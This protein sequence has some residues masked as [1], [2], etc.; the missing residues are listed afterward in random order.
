MTAHLLIIDPQNDFCD[1]HRAGSPAPA[2]PVAGAGSDL[3]RLAAFVR[4]HVRA[5]DN[6][7]VTLDS[8]PSVAI[9]RTTFWQQADGSEVAPFTFLR[10]EDLDAGRIRARSSDPAVAAAAAYTVGEMTRKAGG[11]VVWPVHCVTGTWGH[12]IV[13]PVAEA[14]AA[15]ELDRQRAAFKVLKGEH[16]LTEHFGVFEADVPLDGEARTAYN[17]PLLDRLAASDRVFIA[18]EASSH[19]VAASF[20]QLYNGLTTYDRWPQLV[21]L[22]D[23]MSPVPGF[24]KAAADFFER[25]RDA[26]ALILA[27][28]EALR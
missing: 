10:S 15:W 2:L 14:L 18:G 11:M 3:R 28:S 22:R 26:G 6:I 8:H 16:P 7:T 19:C 24:E 23:C 20:D 9:E 5:I 12:N 1:E 27:T 25:A 4:E 17:W 21:L 13:Q